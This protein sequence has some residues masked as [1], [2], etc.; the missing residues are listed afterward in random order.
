M[1]RGISSD[2]DGY[3]LAEA[4]YGDYQIDFTQKFVER[5]DAYEAEREYIQSKLHRYYEEAKTKKL[6]E[7][8]KKGIPARGF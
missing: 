1:I 8:C 5:Y 6:L 2:Y 4:G 7:E 3:Y